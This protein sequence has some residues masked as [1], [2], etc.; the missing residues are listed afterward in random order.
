MAQRLA[1][2][3]LR[4]LALCLVAGFALAVAVAWLLTL[5]P[6]PFAWNPDNEI[7]TGPD[8][9]NVMVD[10]TRFGVEEATLAWPKE[11][12][13]DRRYWTA[14]TPPYWSR[15]RRPGWRERHVG[16]ECASGWPMRCLMSL[17]VVED[18]H[19]PSKDTMRWGIKI[20]RGYGSH[21]P[22]EGVLPLLPIWPGL[23]VDGLFYGAA[24]WG[25]GVGLVA[26]R[27]A[28]RRRR[29]LCPRCAYDLHATP[30]ACP[31]CGWH[32]GGGA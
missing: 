26:A 13:K 20:I 9:A 2:R 8:P 1:R 14:V 27:S 6:Y 10:R 4:T 7:G 3:A 5:L 21:G 18:T 22:L 32:G 12:Y 16:S 11:V 19:R 30:D 24:V 28:R 23:I 25:L 31:E 29:G 17:V 15:L